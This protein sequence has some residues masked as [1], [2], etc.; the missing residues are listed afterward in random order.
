MKATHTLTV[1]LALALTLATSLTACGDDTNPNPT[2]TACDPDR[3]PIVMAHGF[4]ASG[5]TWASFSRL[6]EANG[7]CQSHL[8]A[9]DWNTLAF[10]R[11]SAVIGLDSAIDAALASTGADQVDLV[12]HSAGGGLGYAY[13]ADPTR[14]AKV[15]A[16]AHIA[17]NPAPLENTDPAPAGPAEAPVPTL[18]LTSTGDL[19]VDAAELPGA[20]N[21]VLPTEDHY[22]AATSTRAFGDVYA[23]F[24]GGARPTT[25]DP[26]DAP[27]ANRKATRT[28]SGKALTLGENTPVPGFTVS[29]FALDSATGLRKSPTADATSTVATD[30]SWGPF[31]VAPDTHYELFLEDPANV[32]RPVHYYRE[33]FASDSHLVY[34]RALPTPG[35]LAGVLISLIPFADE[36]TVLIA[37]SSSQG[38]INGRDTLTMNG[39]TLSTPELASAERTSIAFFIFDDETDQ[40]SAGEVSSFSNAINVFL[41]AIDRFISAD[42][43]PITLTLNGR[44][45][46]VPA[47]PSSTDGAIVA[48]FD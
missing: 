6:F 20:I 22:Q 25:T 13:L 31:T 11:D 8:I 44:T 3:R 23:F 43:A 5:D 42:G 14:A 27:P 19:V 2:P 12:G 4:L 41:T 15:A 46:V 37:F 36:H 34:L 10:D 47:L 28:I 45:L 18:N 32:S 39:E 26:T 35:T 1:S 33:P 7:Y 21:I 29:L 48:T 30:G 9:F 16:Y 38:V 24:N 17:S 40:T